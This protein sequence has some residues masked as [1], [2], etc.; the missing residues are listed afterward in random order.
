[1]SYE[2]VLLRADGTAIAETRSLRG[3][4]VPF[5][6]TLVDEAARASMTERDLT[7]VPL[8]VA[9]QEGREASTDRGALVNRSYGYDFVSLVVRVA[10]RVVYRHPHPI[11]EAIRPGLAAWLSE[12]GASAA[13]AVEQTSPQAGVPAAARAELPVAFALRRPGAPGFLRARHTPTVKGVAVV[14]GGQR[15]PSSFRIRRMSEPPLPSCPP[16]AAD[17]SR[18]LQPEAMATL[19]PAHAAVRVLVV[20]PLARMLLESRVFAEDL[21]EGGFL[22]GHVFHALGDTAGHVALVTD[23]LAAEHTGASLL[24]FAFTGDSF[25]ALQQHLRH[26]H[27]PQAR[28]LLGWYHTHLF[29]ATASFGL[30]SIDVRLHFTTFR[31][32]WQLAAL[33]NIDPHRRT[34]VLRFYARQHGAMVRCEQALVTA[35]AAAALVSAA[36]STVDPRGDA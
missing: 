21:E 6:A 4:V 24:H 26:E 11:D 18:P 22:L 3:L 20:E 17:A 35:E 32:P 30:S 25:A 13:W 34:R 16:L 7:V 23:A 5:A 33:V 28:R 12:L 27:G 9:E 10:G 14:L 15:P 19:E 2:V 29:P 8:P 1:M 31:I 36:G